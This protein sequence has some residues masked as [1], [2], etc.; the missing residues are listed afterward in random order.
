MTWTVAPLVRLSI[1]LTPLSPNQAGKLSFKG[2]D[3]EQF[4]KGGAPQLP[5]DK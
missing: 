1:N 3:E 2:E 4:L 5:L